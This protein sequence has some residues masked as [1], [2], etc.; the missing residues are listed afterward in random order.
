MKATRLVDLRAELARRDLQGFIVPRADEHLGE[1]VPAGAERLAWLTGFTGSAGLAMVLPDRAAAFTD[2]RYVLQLAA[3]TDPALWERRHI[4]EEPPPAWLAEH[5]PPGARIGYDPLLVSEEGLARYTEAGIT[6]VPVADNP[7]DAIWKD[8]PAAPLEP[9]QPHRLEFAGRSSDQK[10]EEVA[11]VL[12]T[13][14]QDAA[15]VTDPASIA[16]LL[17]IR[18]SDVPFTPFALGFA[19]VH[20]D[21]GCELFMAPQKLPPETREWL[22]N[23]VSVQDR[24][25]LPDALAGLAG[26]R[27][28]GRCR[29]V[30]G[31]VR[32]ATSR[33]RGRGA[34]GHG[35]LH[36]A[37]SLQEP[38]GAAGRPRCARPA[39]RW[40]CAASCAGW[41]PRRGTRAN[42]RRRPSCWNSA[43]R[44]RGSGARVSR[45]SRAPGKMARS[46]TTALPRKPIGRS[47]PTRPT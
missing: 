47:A 46:S 19:I 1:Y 4:T 6:M 31:V 27:V 38:G 17:N 26:K 10:R 40:R 18:G 25:A 22:G 3:Q 24:A 11:A 32:P 13:S 23:A 44:W 43:S 16:W 20:A 45:R 2:G 15:V 28:R 35:P 21:A 39:T 41:R 34:A 7:I 14:K 9:A 33:R 29:R 42:Y 30:A 36:V 12:R 8:R 37:E 5:A